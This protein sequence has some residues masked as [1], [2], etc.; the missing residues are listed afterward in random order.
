VRFRN[1]LQGIM[2]LVILACTIFSFGCFN[3]NNPVVSD[4]QSNSSLI[5]GTISQSVVF[6]SRGLVDITSLITSTGTG[7]SPVIDGDLSTIVSSPSAFQPVTLSFSWNKPVQLGCFSYYTQ[8]RRWGGFRFFGRRHCDGQWMELQSWNH[9]FQVIPNCLIT[10][11]V[12]DSGALFFTDLT[13]TIYPCNWPGSV[14]HTPYVILNEVQISGRDMFPPVKILEPEKHQ[15]DAGEE[16]YLQGFNTV[17][18]NYFEWVS[19][20]DGIVGVSQYPSN[21]FYPGTMFPWLKTRSL[22]PGLHNISLQIPALYIPT[23]DINYGPWVTEPMQV[24]IGPSSSSLCIVSPTSDSVFDLGQTI[25]FQG[26]KTGTVTNF[27]WESNLDGFIGSD[28]PSIATSGLR[29][30]THT[31]TLSGTDSS[32]NPLSDSILVGIKGG[33]PRISKL[34][35]LGAN[36]NQIYDRKGDYKKNRPIGDKYLEPFQ[37]EGEIVNDEIKQK[38]SFPHPISYVRSGASLGTSKLRFKAYFKDLANSPTLSFTASVSGTISGTPI[39]FTSAPVTTHG[40]NETEVEFESTTPLPDTVGIWDLVLSWSFDNNGTNLGSQRIPEVGAQTLFTTWGKPVT[41]GYY[42]HDRN[43]VEIKEAVLYLEITKM[44]CRLLQPLNFGSTK[45]PANIKESLLESYYFHSG[46]SYGPRNKPRPADS[47]IDPRGLDSLLIHSYGWCGE[48]SVLLKALI[49]GQGVD[50]KT[51]RFIL[52]PKYGKEWHL[53]A[54]GTIP[55]IGGILSAMWNC[56]DWVFNDHA[57]V[58][59]TII[60]YDP[61]FNK[62][63]LFPGY[64]NDL[65]DI[66]HNNLFVDPDPIPTYCNADSYFDQ[67]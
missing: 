34:E 51:R 57:I 56:S 23:Y 17:H 59:D 9:E 12:I 4:S 14:F 19:D 5:K 65:W 16:V 22:T 11:Y 43:Y 3:R 47:K 40:S 30:G 6:P 54:I 33:K 32:G 62:K 61:C 21:N 42:Q 63:G 66:F 28:F 67:D 15:F 49:E 50:V 7:T 44:S 10:G 26:E 36:R 24:Q 25:S 39:S 18:F 27:R 2:I 58:L 64:V 60:A 46:F 31:I 13:I 8:N 29:V 1:L 37:W 52:R 55:A 48:H 41:T 45:T 20:R 38:E 35:F 53:V